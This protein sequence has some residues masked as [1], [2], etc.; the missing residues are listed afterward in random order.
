M[1]SAPP[2]ANLLQFVGLSGDKLGLLF[3][4]LQVCVTAATP[5]DWQTCYVLRKALHPYSS[6]GK[7]HAI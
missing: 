4:E 1:I 7:G 3:L 5:T 6:V 2:R